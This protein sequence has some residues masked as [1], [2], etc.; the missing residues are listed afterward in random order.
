MSRGIRKGDPNYWQWRK[1]TGKPKSI[2]NPK[3]LWDAACDYFEWC[4]ENP[5]TKQDF[6]R[7][8]DMAGS[9]VD[10][11]IPR[12]YTWQGLESHLA[13]M[14]LVS[15]LDD[16]RANVGKAYEKYKDSLTRIEREIYDRKYVGAAT[17]TYN[18]GFISKDLGIT[19]KI[20]QQVSVV[21][22]PLFG[23]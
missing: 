20:E 1:N 3:Q 22:Q 17:N 2:K 9:K 14:G 16:Y 21:E 13:D 8:G 23:D 11:A 7:G 18:A 15:K 6:I 12:P 5:M 4:D 10:L 19:E